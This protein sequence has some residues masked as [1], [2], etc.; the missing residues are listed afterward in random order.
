MRVTISNGV[1]EST[2]NA[3]MLELEGEHMAHPDPHPAQ[4]K[5]AATVMLVRDSKPGRT[6]FRI[7][8]GNF[9]PDF[10]NDQDVEVFM[11]RRVKAMDFAP[12]AVA[13]PG[14]RVDVRD[15][16]PDLP[17]CGPTPAEWAALLGV[18]EDDARR[19]VVAAVRELF[20][21]CGVLLAGPDEA[22]TVIDLGDPSW[23]ADREALV[24][25]KIAFA[26]LLIQRGLVLRSDLLGLVSNWCTPAYEPK[27]FDTFFFS[28]LVPEGQIADGNTSEAQIADWVTPS[29]AIR[30]SDAGRWLLFPPTIYNLGQ[31]AEAPSASAFVAQRKKVYKVVPEAFHKDD[32]TIVMRAKLPS[33]L[34]S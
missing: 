29:F 23:G 26:D 24:A 2:P 5:L 16:N 11:F 21:E 4:P 31:I 20:E 13:F 14:G 1:I 9:P 19:I 28:A 6:S 7:E 33:G 18:A 30:E 3:K 22:S 34:T 12:D 25:H 8:E 15:A 10:P 32:G 27:R 17:W